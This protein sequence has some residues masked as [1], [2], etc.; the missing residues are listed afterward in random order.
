MIGLVR[1]RWAIFSGL[2]LLMLGY[3]VWYNLP[4]RS[5]TYTWHERILVE[6]STPQG[7]VT[8][9]VVQGLRVKYYPNGLFA[10]GTE[11]VWEL[12]GEALLVD[13]GEAL[14]PRRYLFGLFAGT[15]YQAP[16]PAEKGL[17]KRE[18]FQRNAALVDG[19]PHEIRLS[20]WVGFADVNDPDSMF[21]VDST[22]LA[23]SYG[24]GYSM[25]GQTRQVTADPVTAGKI[26]AVLPWLN[27]RKPLPELVLPDGRIRAIHGIMFDKGRF[28]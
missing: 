27:S 19:K 13:L 2:I 6:V 5:E 20:L 7:P 9:A 28:K 11:T 21:F 14:G 24:E 12:A 15:E 23:K 1:A 17:T 10:T 22:N 8:S 3:L 26:R 18:R 4:F 25:I 16:D